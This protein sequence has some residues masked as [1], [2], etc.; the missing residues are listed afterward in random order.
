M[1]TPLPRSAS[2]WQRLRRWLGARTA[3]QDR[4]I[5][6]TLWQATVGTLPFLSALPPDEQAGLRR[7]CGHFL[8]R[9]EFHGAH[10]LPVT[11]AMALTVAAQA[12]LPLLHLEPGAGS[13]GDP[14]ALAWYDDFV[15]IVLHP[16]LALARRDF[17]D[18]DGIVHQWQEELAGEAMPG[19]P[20]MLS[21][22]DV[23]AA[24]ESAA[25]GYNVVIHEFIHKMDLRDGA[26]DACPPLPP[27]FL[28]QQ[29]A[30][31]ARQ[32]WLAVLTPAWEGF[33]E[34]VIRAE[35]FGQ[36][37]PWLDAYGAQS[38]D[39]FLAVACEAYFVNRAEFGRHFP[40]LLTL[41]DA[42]FRPTR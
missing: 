13:P 4:P 6:D 16:G 3:P 10:G 42:F 24:G 11:D 5:P 27:G 21:W 7:L 39:E 33:C 18:D 9:K 12:C 23:A 36:A 1:N 19:G 14:R 37:E 28:G 15:G 2:P 35:R 30:R 25:Q 22:P 38:L 34:Q 26:A 20:V 31:A 17:T 32:A 40:T 41:F 8:A 29:G